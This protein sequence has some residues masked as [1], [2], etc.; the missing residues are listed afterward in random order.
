[1]CGQGLT[2]LSSTGFEDLSFVLLRGTKL[3]EQALVLVAC[4]HANG[5]LNR[6]QKGSLL[7][8]YPQLSKPLIPLMFGSGKRVVQNGRHG[9]RLR[10]GINRRTESRLAAAS[11]GGGRLREDF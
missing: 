8:G 5:R 1:M 4:L 11:I 9:N 7:R 10:E 2:D 6:G 3:V